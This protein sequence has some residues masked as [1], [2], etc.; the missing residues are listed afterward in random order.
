MTSVISEIA[1]PICHSDNESI[2]NSFGDEQQPKTELAGDDNQ[3]QQNSTSQQSR[4][5][6]ANSQD[7]AGKSLLIHSCARG[8]KNIVEELSLDEHIDVN[9]EDSEGNTALIHAAQAGYTQIIELLIDRFDKLEID[10]VN[11][12]G[13]TA[14][15]KAAI[16]GRANCA[17]ILLCAGADPNK[18]DNGRQMTAL[19]WAKFVGRTECG[20][21]I[22]EFGEPKRGGDKQS[23]QNSA[24]SNFK[25][26]ACVAAIPLVGLREVSALARPR[27]RS[28]PPT[29][30]VKIRITPPPSPFFQN[31]ETEGTAQQQFPFKMITKQNNSS[32]NRPLRTEER[33]KSSIM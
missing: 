15:I 9:L 33:P 11:K 20:Q 19:E 31:I 16:Q 21:V 18:R 1:F 4:N 8:L 6:Q 7:S 13:Q 29:P 25:Q 12:L 23:L 10:H 2:S 22:R 28:A 27:V 5:C 17:R 24:H 3:S 26:V 30:A 14:L 32:K